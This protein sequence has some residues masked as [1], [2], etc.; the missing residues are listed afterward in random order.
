YT[1]DDGGQ[2]IT[3]SGSLARSALPD[4][5]SDITWD[6]ANRLTAAGTPTLIY[7]AHGNLNG[8]G[9]RQYF[10]NARDQLV[11]IKDNAGAVIA[12]FT[13]DALGRRQTKM[14][15]GVATGYVYDGLNIVQELAGTASA[16]NDL[17]SVRASYI[18]AGLDE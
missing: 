1:Y 16:N 5:L 15:D 4:A 6:S 10:W 2:R 3:T 18:S 7:A 14:V 12:A 9:T 11:Q 17:P 8:D 13:Y